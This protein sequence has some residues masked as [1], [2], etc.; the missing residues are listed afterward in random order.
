MKK[1]LLVFLVLF[2][3]AF[4][5]RDR[6]DGFFIGEVVFEE[7]KEMLSQDFGNINVYFCP[8]EDCENILLREIEDS[9]LV[10]CAFFDLNLESVIE[11]IRLK[12][13][14]LIIDDANF[15]KVEM[16]FVRKDGKQGLMHN[17]FCI[18]DGS[19]VVTGSMNPTKNGVSRN[20]NNLVL[21][22]SRTLADNYLDEFNEMW[23]GSFGKG[24]KV[25]NPRVMFNSFL[26]ENLFCPDDGCENRVIEILNGAKGRIYFMTF[27]FTSDG[28][29]EE[30]IKNYHYGVDIKGV[31]ERTQ[32]GSKYSEYEKF[33]ELGM[34]VKLDVNKGAMHHK[35]FIV[36]DIVVFG[37][38]NPSKSGDSKNDENVL[39]VHDSS[40][41]GLFVE[42][43]ERVYGLG[44][45][46]D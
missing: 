27:S 14:K 37:S 19:K 5:V 29:G 23:G 8:Q 24:D 17:K 43:F 6:F 3:V 40:V 32:A 42:E 45:I 44:E 1:I 11:A 18:L 38:Y 46:E 12:E 4:F 22:E 30:I 33:K 13:H 2:V 31:F 25:R 35:V 26:I 20:N 21:I 16:D 7:N 36:D 34:D 15:D 39:I 10:Y 41:A 9:N 28:I